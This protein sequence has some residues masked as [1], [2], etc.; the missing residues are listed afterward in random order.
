MA[1]V[2]ECAH[3][4]APAAPGEEVLGTPIHQVKVGAGGAK[5]AQNA[6]G[7]DFEVGPIFGN[8]VPVA[9]SRF[10][11]GSLDLVDELLHD[12]AQTAAGLR[13]LAL[14]GQMARLRNN[15]LASDADLTFD[16]QLDAKAFQ[17]PQNTSACQLDVMSA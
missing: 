4:V 13:R 1:V 6:E 3:K 5:D 14:V 17:G 9:V 12:A 11:P 8:W 2:Q 10:L 15:A 16:A 7:V